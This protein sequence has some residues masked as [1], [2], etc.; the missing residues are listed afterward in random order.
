MCDWNSIRISQV[1]F[2]ENV[3][4]FSLCENYAE[5]VPKSLFRNSYAME[6]AVYIFNII[7]IELT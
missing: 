4:K 2:L 3:R 1:N 6:G 7:Y 5:G